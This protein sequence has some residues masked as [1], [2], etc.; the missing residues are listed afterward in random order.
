MSVYGASV[1]KL[2]VAPDAIPLQQTDDAEKQPFISFLDG[3]VWAYLHF[4]SGSID[5]YTGYC[6]VAPYIE[7]NSALDKRFRQVLM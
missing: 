2:I 1:T 4:S 3:F 6:E 7:Q 5:P